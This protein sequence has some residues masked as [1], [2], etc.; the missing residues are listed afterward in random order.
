VEDHRFV[1]IGGLH[2]SGTS[3]IFRC[4]REHPLISGFENTGAPQDEGQ[5]LQSVY[6]PGDTYGGPGRFGFEPEAHL[7]ETSEL[8]TK[9][10]R[11]RLLAEWKRHWDLEKPVLLEKSPPNLIRMR[12]LQELFPNPYFLVVIRHPIAVSYATRE[13]TNA[14]L[15]E[16][17]EHW[18]VCHEKF[19]QDRQHVRRLFVLK[20]EDFVEKPQAA[21]DTIYSFLGLPHYPNRIQVHSRL[22]EKYLKQWPT[23]QNDTLSGG[24]M[25]ATQIRLQS[26]RR[27]AAF[28][29]SL[30]GSSP[31]AAKLVGG[32]PDLS[33]EI[34]W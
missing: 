8:I 6:P 2:R 23:Y 9:E 18:L 32:R 31:T 3:V 17:I 5:H 20:Y 11:L 28:G 21:L 15:P 14:S 33:E 4:L 26:E 27:V 25:E 24:C 22:N 29:Y 13:W 1:F 34:T 19:E 12:F 30:D 7:T 16:L 10:N